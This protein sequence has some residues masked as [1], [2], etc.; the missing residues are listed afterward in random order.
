MSFLRT[1]FV[2]VASASDQSC[3]LFNSPQ[4]S[5]N[6]VS[7][8]DTFGTGIK[9]KTCLTRNQPSSKSLRQQGNA[10]RKVFRLKK[11]LQVP[12]F[13]RSN[14]RD[15]SYKEQNHEAELVVAKAEEKESVSADPAA[16]VDEGQDTSLTKSNNVTKLLKNRLGM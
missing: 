11:K 3:E 5:S 7:N 1:L 4:G 6:A 16:I 13:Y 15:L 9:L 2:S 10:P 8:G 14:F 12:S